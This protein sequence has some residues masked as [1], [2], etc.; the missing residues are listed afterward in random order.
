MHGEIYQNAYRWVL[1]LNPNLRVLF[2]R[3]GGINAAPRR[4]RKSYTARADN[5]ENSWR[6]Y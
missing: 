6:R 5:A 2:T 3:C 1:T 4:A